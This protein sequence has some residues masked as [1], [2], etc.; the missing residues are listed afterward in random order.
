MLPRY[1]HLGQHK[2]PV[3]LQGMRRIGAVEHVNAVDVA[4]VSRIRLL[5]ETPDTTIN[6]SAIDDTAQE[7]LNLPTDVVQL[8]HCRALH[9][10][11]EANVSDY[12]VVAP[13]PQRDL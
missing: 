8:Q 1:W 2:K 4:T 10:R 5:V 7:L 11:S 12:A 13:R 9:H 3:V 6:A